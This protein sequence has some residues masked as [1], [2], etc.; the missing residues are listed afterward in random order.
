MSYPTVRALLECYIVTYL[1]GLIQWV[2]ERWWFNLIDAVQ[3]GRL[4]VP[5][6]ITHTHIVL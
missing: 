4:E 1:E 6:H 5:P 2:V 3:F